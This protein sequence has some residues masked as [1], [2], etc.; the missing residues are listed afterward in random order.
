MAIEYKCSEE[1][2]RL[3]V[4]RMIKDQ[5]VS[6]NA[7]FNFNNSTGFRN[8]V[9]YRDMDFLEALAY[10]DEMRVVDDVIG[11]LVDRGM[12]GKGT[13]FY[14][15]QAFLDLRMFVKRNFKGEW[16]TITPVLERMLYMLSSVR[17][18]KRILA[19]GIFWGNAFIWNVGSSCGKGKV[20]DAE[21]V[22]GVDID[23]HA[24]EMAQANI[25]L[26]PD[27]KHIELVVQEGV[28]FATE[29][30][31][32]FD[33][34]YLDVGISQIEKSLNYPILNAL[35]SKLEK[36]AWVLTHDTTHPY[37]INSFVEY[38]NFVR[39]KDYFS[40]SICLDIDQYGLEL[41]IKG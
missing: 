5:K 8:E 20:Y 13:A 18:P 19:I 40:E 24:I 28:K 15:K 2:V 10:A 11:L 3:A 35:Y 9:A 39:N 22:I 38:L 29:T 26:I 41:S 23:P 37:F 27:N 6:A 32:T 36:G 17:R 33:Y 1:T 21:S 34:V 30:T 25:N 31:G 12:I 7:S 4:R 14:D 16:G